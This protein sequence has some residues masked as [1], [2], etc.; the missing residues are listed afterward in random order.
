MWTRQGALPEVRFVMPAGMPEARVTGDKVR[1]TVRAALADGRT[2][3]RTFFQSPEA[4]AAALTISVE[5]PHKGGIALPDLDFPGAVLTGRFLIVQN[6][7]AGE[8][9]PDMAASTGVEPL[10][11]DTMGELHFTV[12]GFSNPLSWRLKPGWKLSAEHRTLETTSGPQA[13]V[14]WAELTTMLRAEGPEWLRAVY[15][16]QNRALQFLPLRLP[17]DLELVSAIVAE[18]PVRADTGTLPD[19]KPGLLIP[20]IQTRPGDLAMDVE[21]VCRVR[22]AS[23]VRRSRA[24][25]LDDPDIPGVSIQ[26]TLWN[27]WT[28]PGWDL[29][30]AGGNMERV[31]EKKGFMEKL[32]ASFD[33]LESLGSY[34]RTSRNAAFRANAWQQS[35]VLIDRME[36][37]VN[38]A[39]SSRSMAY[40][41]RGEGRE[42]LQKARERL[43]QAK[44]VRSKLLQ[45][46]DIH[47]TRQT[48]AQFSSSGTS[49]DIWQ[50]DFNSS[51]LIQRAR[52]SGSAQDRTESI[53][54]GNQLLNGGVLSGNSVILSKNAP[55]TAPAEL[56]KPAPPPA[57]RRYNAQIAALNEEDDAQGR[58]AD[59]KVDRRSALKPDD[60]SSGKEGKGEAGDQRELAQS[61]FN[62]VRGASRRRIVPPAQPPSA[63]TTPL[64]GLLPAPALPPAT[65]FPEAATATPV[66]APPPPAP[67]VLKP[68]GR[69]SIPVFLAEEGTVHRFRKVN[70]RASLSLTIKP[71]SR[72]TSSRWLAAGVLAA[73]M[74]VLWLVNRKGRKRSTRKAGSQ[75]AAASV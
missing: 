41:E 25:T 69:V 40:Y 21:I 51:Y 36:Q 10:A 17:E 38:E 33:E 68:A 45:P 18:T 49:G 15:H 20:L 75:A 27:V 28:P 11:R 9:V 22:N 1:E 65:P 50:W 5:L 12:Q 23:V 55:D 39:E 42:E 30:D 60:S 57:S 47:G 24:R 29:D 73:G 16:L 26:R 66:A 37:T 3:Y 13:V 67:P 62:D 70:D 56:R 2:E 31:E 14:L 46:G 72:S 48:P 63:A 58:I 74:G 7:S 71:L 64:A 53:I 59:M 19:G 8:I 43:E 44:I 32:E 4:D 34:S 61:A 6:F 52:D 54:A 35:D